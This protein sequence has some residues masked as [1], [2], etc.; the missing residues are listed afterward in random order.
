MDW[1]GFYGTRIVVCAA[2]RQAA[3]KLATREAVR[4]ATEQIVATGYA[5]GIS[6][7]S[8]DA[9]DKILARSHVYRAEA[10]AKI[11]RLDNLAITL[12]AP[13]RRR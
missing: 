3:I 9:Q 5:Y 11:E 6:G 13:G 8:P 1:D 4:H 12:S 10:H 7:T 2:E